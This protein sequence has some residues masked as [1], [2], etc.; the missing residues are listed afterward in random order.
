MNSH[1]KLHQRGTANGRRTAAAERLR[2]WLVRLVSLILLLLP[3]PG[4]AQE[5]QQG[6]CAQVK[7][8]ISQELTLE[9]VGFLATLQI[10]D[11]DPNDPITDFGGLFLSMNIGFN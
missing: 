4:L 11:N 9:R 3:S 5:Q 8:V 10:T 2:S 1:Q 6:L 7:I